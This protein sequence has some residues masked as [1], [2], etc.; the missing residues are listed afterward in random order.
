MGGLMVQEYAGD[1]FP[2]QWH[3]A[4]ARISLSC[5]DEIDRTAMA[6]S[7]S[8]LEGWVGGRWLMLAAEMAGLADGRR[9]SSPDPVSAGQARPPHLASG[10]IDLE[11]TRAVLDAAIA[12]RITLLDTADRYGGTR[13]EEFLCTLLR[14]RPGRWQS[15][16]IA[17]SRL[18]R[19]GPP[20][21]DRHAHA[22]RRR[23]IS[24]LRPGLHHRY[25]APVGHGRTQPGHRDRRV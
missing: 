1:P 23:R 14:G 18:G 24:P 9:R 16:A 25:L 2:S 6:A 22:R 4:G 11:Q 12:E 5:R 7:P 10:R 20:T 3:H 19:P 15:A 21:A 17:G 13:S 8:R